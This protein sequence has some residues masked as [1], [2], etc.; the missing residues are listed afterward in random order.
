MTQQA[1]KKEYNTFVKG[2]ITEAGALTFPENASLDEANCVLNRDGSRQRRLGMDFEDDFVLRTVTVEAD[3]AI[4]SYRWPN[5][6]NDVDNQLAVVQAGQTLFIFD[7]T[8]ASISANLL[9]TVD[10]SAYVTGKTVLGT[11]SGMGYFF[12]TD[13]TTKPLYLSYNPS[14]FAVTATEIDIEIR[15]IFG[16]DDGLDVD[17]NPGSLSTA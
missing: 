11:D 9:D 10:L 14:T 15:D 16:V 4:A 8:Q 3:D 17:E 2:I 7:A 12:V 6:A 13:G 1:T 5:A